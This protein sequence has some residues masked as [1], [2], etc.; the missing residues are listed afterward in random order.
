MSRRESW[1]IIIPGFQ[2]DYKY[3]VIAGA[4]NAER[5]NNFALAEN[6]GNN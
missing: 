4:R 3:R 5:D 1:I 2:K 6:I